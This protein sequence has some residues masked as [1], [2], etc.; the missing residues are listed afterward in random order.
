MLYYQQEIEVRLS[1]T[2]FE[3]PIRLCFGDISLA[4]NT[5]QASWLAATLNQ[6]VTAHHRRRISGA[7]PITVEEKRNLQ[8]NESVLVRLDDGHEDIF[9][10]RAVPWKLN[11]G[12]WLIGLTGIV[13]GYDLSRVVGRMP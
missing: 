11:H 10:V 9:V 2:D 8:V 12:A 13:G 7:V 4:L 6:R 5:V 3:E 1:D